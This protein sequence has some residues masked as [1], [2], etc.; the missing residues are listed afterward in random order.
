MTRRR[1]LQTGAITGLAAVSAIPAGGCSREKSAGKPS[2]AAWKDLASKLRGRVL[3]PGD[4][5]FDAVGLPVNLRFDAIRPAGVA[6]C[7]T[8]EDVAYA[9][10]WSQDNGLPQVPRS[11]GHNYMGYSTNQ[12]L[13]IS[14][15]E[16]NSVRHQQNSDRI[17]AGGG[18]QNK[19]VAKALTPAHV[20][21]PGGQCPTVGVAGLTLGGGLG[22]S[23]RAL[24]VT[25]DSLMA[26]QLV[27]ANGDIV[28]ASASE[29]PDLF[30]GLRG[31]TGGNL[32]INTEFTY[33]ANPAKDCTHFVVEFAA[34]RT[35]DMLDAWFTMLATAPREL[36]LIWY[37]VPGATPAD[38]PLCGTFGQ[39]YG[40]ASDTRDVLAP[41]IRS[42]GTPVT[43]EFHE[44][45]Y[46]DAV[47]FLAS[48][49]T[50]HGFQ[51]RS[52][53][54][55]QRFSGDAIAALTARLDRQPH[56][57][58]DVSI[59]GW[60]GAISDTAPDATAFVHRG[61]T[62]LIK[63]SAAWNPGDNTTRDASTQWVHETFE[64]MQ[65]HCSRRSFQNFPDG[66]LDDWA[67]S[68]YGENLKRLIEVKRKYDPDRVFNFPQ[69]IPTA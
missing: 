6:V 67:Q 49:S 3:R 52:R 13:V 42:G 44:G 63:Y 64:A 68:Y 50:P 21:I 57:R 22:F 65:P 43:E 26:T 33:T 16:M 60:G 10:K 69:A 66:E 51:D 32:G 23:M 58:G 55:D 9:L 5:Q 45:T 34:E 37:Y 30:W 8:P 53:F 38:K 14:V 40:S 62:A 59:F 4:T 31:G 41:V 39:M 25:S 1:F 15:S 20:M 56:N 17:I 7:A 11:G 24:G 36:G 28:T 48:N 47:A 46:W 27:L 29:N 2:D 35:A 12:G 19:D 54:L 18:A 61:A